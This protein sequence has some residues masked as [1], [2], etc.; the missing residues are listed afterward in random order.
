MCT[1]TARHQTGTSQYIESH[2]TSLQARL[3][4]VVFP[5][6]AQCAVERRCKYIHNFGTDKRT[7]GPVGDLSRTCQGYDLMKMC[8]LPDRA[9]KMAVLTLTTATDLSNNLRRLTYSLPQ[10]YQQ[11]LLCSPQHNCSPPTFVPYPI[12][13][14]TLLCLK[15][16]K[17]STKVNKIKMY[18]GAGNTSSH[19]Q[20]HCI[21]C[22]N[23][24]HTLNP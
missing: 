19:L 11:E 2:V 5:N 16:Q 20:L 6:W 12:H 15:F 14:S 1:S 23:K 8:K 13:H 7:E 10:A 18:L 3:V 22:L 21:H 9:F 4:A 24:P 17:L